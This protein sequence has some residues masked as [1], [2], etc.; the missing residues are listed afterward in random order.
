MKGKQELIRFLQRDINQDSFYE[1]YCKECI[2]DL[3]RVEIDCIFQE[4]GNKK[5]L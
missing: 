1:Q 2:T 3:I 5:I 4:K